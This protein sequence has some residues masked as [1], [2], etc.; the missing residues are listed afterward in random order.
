MGLVSGWGNGFRK[1]TRTNALIR[2]VVSYVR[3]PILCWADCTWRYLRDELPLRNVSRSQ[4]LGRSWLVASWSSSRWTRSDS[5]EWVRMAFDWRSMKTLASEA[6]PGA[7][8]ND[9][10]R[11]R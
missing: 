6:R 1:G 4:G 11:C 5:S 3:S 8:P 2:A 7:R 9:L 10:R